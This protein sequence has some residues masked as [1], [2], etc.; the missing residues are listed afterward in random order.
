MSASNKIVL[1]SA[2]ALTAASNTST[3][4][5]AEV[6]FADFVGFIKTT[7]TNGATTVTAKIQ[8][9]P[10]GSDWFDLVSFTALVGVNGSEEKEVLISGGGSPRNSVFPQ[11]RAS[12]ALAGATKASTVTI[13]LYHS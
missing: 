12:V 4:Q 2:Q 3:A 13:E 8:H 9:S 11:V 5:A 6:K 7:A 10:N 1:Y